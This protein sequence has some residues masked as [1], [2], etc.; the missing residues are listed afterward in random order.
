MKLANRPKNQRKERDKNDILQ[1]IF[2]AMSRLKNNLNERK[3]LEDLLTFM[4]A[5]SRRQATVDQQM[6]AL[7][8]TYLGVDSPAAQKQKGLE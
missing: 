3:S 1:D 5:E 4:E 7:L 2:N 6:L 8:A